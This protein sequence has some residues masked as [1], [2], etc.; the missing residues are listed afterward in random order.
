MVETTKIGMPLEEFVRLNDEQPFELI[1]GERRPKLPTVFGHS[2]II[3]ML[4]LALYMYVTSR[5][6]GEVYSETTFVLPD[7]IVR[8][9]VEGSRTPDVM[10][11]AGTRVAVYKTEHPDYRA[12]PLALVP[13]F[14]IEVISPTDKYSEVDEKVDA[15]LADGVRL[16]WVIDPQRRKATIHTPD[17][18]QP[19]HL[20]G[21]V[22]LD[23]SEV[24]AGFQIG[25]AT[26][27]EG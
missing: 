8:N 6:L 7:T 17:A 10:F 5:Q 19:T 1:N 20:S 4:F 23:A 12:N 21:E 22:M 2:E 15:Y 9:W 25:L 24:I 18:E 11:Y 3:R 14:V 26:L 16:I 13:D 27:F